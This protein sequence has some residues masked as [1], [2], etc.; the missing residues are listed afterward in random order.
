MASA[1]INLDIK[2]SLLIKQKA[3][4][5]SGRGLKEVCSD[6]INKHGISKKDGQALRDGT[7]LSAT[8]IDRLSKLTDTELGEPYRPQAET[9][10]RV[11]R[12][13]GAELYFDQVI[14]KPK[15][16]NKPKGE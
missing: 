10:E 2:N 8:T 3:L 6:L 11:F 14:I 7:F 4:G 12:Y 16:L 5:N 13:F 1:E 9:L 15:F